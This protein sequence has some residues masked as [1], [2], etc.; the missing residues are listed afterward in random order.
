MQGVRGDLVFAFSMGTKDE[1]Y[2]AFYFTNTKARRAQEGKPVLLVMERTEKQGA[3]NNLIVADHLMVNYRG[4]V[5]TRAEQAATHNAPHCA[6]STDPNVDVCP[7]VLVPSSSP[8]LD[9]LTGFME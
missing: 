9:P 2:G 6:A 3:L 7:D 1:K 4:Q 8:S 5:V